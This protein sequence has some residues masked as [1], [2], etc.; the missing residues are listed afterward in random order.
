MKNW[1]GVGKK[2]LLEHIS[3][4]LAT[5]LVGF[6]LLPGIVNA[7]FKNRH[8]RDL[9]KAFNKLN[10]FVWDKSNNAPI[11]V[12][13]LTSP[14]SI[15]HAFHTNW[16]RPAT[17]ARP[18]SITSYSSKQICKLFKSSA[19]SLYTLYSSELRQYLSGHVLHSPFHSSKLQIM[20]RHT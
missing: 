17:S 20:E 14:S 19:P 10:S 11:H 5:L 13:T 2:T 7:K 3:F 1:Y 16:L 6:S 12:F 18:P 15:V 9:L 4:L 8:R